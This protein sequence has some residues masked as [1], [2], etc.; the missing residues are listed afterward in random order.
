MINELGTRKKTR[1]LA[2]KDAATA[3]TGTLAKVSLSLSLSLKK[4]KKRH[5]LKK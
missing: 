1:T 3:Y 2:L 5:A 4:K